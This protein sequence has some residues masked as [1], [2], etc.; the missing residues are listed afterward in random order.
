MKK[1]I[2]FVFIFI[3]ILKGQT[4]AQNFSPIFQDI[5]TTPQYS[6]EKIQDGDI[7]SIDEE[8][9]RIVLSKVAYDNHMYGIA[10][11]DPV[12]VFRTREST[13]AART[14]NAYVNVTTL[15]GPIE[16][17]DYLTSSEIPGKAQKA[18]AIQGYVLG[19]ALQ[20]FDGKN[21][22]DVTYEGKT[23]KVGKILTTIGIGPASA[24]KIRPGGGLFGTLKYLAQSFLI[25]VQVAE[26]L[27]DWIRYALAFL[28]ATTSII[29]SF[30]YFGR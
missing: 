19:L 15:N 29:V 24:V 25:N 27:S 16:V 18:G 28:I 20:S 10:I 30:R 7:L 23:Y 2:L 21:G 14:G 8:K 3:F 6:N 13:P 11:I 22:K 5:A 1:N 4:L 12:I 9:K 26:N 17:G